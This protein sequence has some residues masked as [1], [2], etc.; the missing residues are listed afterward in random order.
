MGVALVHFFSGPN[1]HVNLKTLTPNHTVPKFKVV[2]RVPLRPAEALLDAY[3][4]S[5]VT[6]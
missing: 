1:K 2:E 4:P 6:A 5:R 3:R